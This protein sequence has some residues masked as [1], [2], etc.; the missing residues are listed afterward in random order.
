LELA[1]SKQPHDS[2]IVREDNY[3]ITG[4]PSPSTSASPP[5][6]KWWI[7]IAISMALFMSAT[8]GTTMNLALPTL[9]REFKSTFA[10]VQW[11]VLA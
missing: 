11:V 7:L 3:V 8:N 4:A 6:N 2:T 1:A 10:A 5:T 9:L